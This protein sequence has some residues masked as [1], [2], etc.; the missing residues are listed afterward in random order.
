[1]AVTIVTSSLKNNCPKKQKV[2]TFIH[3]KERLKPP[4]FRRAAFC[5]QLTYTGA[6]EY[7]QGSHTQ[8][9][10]ECH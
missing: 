5:W 10:I 3:P 4:P 6:M 1:M 9:K 2:F 7:R 8:Y